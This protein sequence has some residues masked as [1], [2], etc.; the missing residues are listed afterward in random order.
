[1][2]RIFPT[3]SSELELSEHNTGMSETWR[4]AGRNRLGYCMVVVQCM[5]QKRF[6]GKPVCSEMIHHRGCAYPGYECDVKKEME[7][8]VRLKVPLTVEIKAADNWLDAH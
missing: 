3:R 6:R 7:N 1:M 8:A 2:V 4:E 5:Y